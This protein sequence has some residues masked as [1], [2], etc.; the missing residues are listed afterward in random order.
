M[1]R[2]L[3]LVLGMMLV[4][5]AAAA[6]AAAAEVKIGVVDLT[7]VLD[8]SD[9][10]KAANAQLATLT[11]S[12]QDELAAMKSKIDALQKE[13]DGG[14]LSAADKKS[15]QDDLDKQQQAYQ[16][17]VQDDQNQL[18]QTAQDLRN[19]L[20]NDIGQ[21]LGMIGD[22][23]GYT[24]IVDAQSVFYHQKVIDLTYDLIRKYNDLY[25][26]AQKSQAGGAAASGGSATGN[27]AATDAKTPA[28]AASGSSGK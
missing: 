2:A 15:K 23:E 22:Q 16:K 27:S 13:I 6:S 21:V 25:A 24:L 4:F 18:Q 19:Q 20:L 3:A 17:A 11:K 10:G 5:G 14:K 12:K 26:Q 9:A 1:K 8:Q 28:P 7:T